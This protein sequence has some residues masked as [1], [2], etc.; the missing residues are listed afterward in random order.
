MS[1]FKRYFQ[2]NNIVFITLVT[3]NRQPILI[4]NINFLRESLINPK[5]NYKIIA[6]VVLPD[7]IH[8]LIQNDNANEFSKLISSIKVSFSKHFPLN[9]EQTEKQLLR[10]EKGIWQR[11]YYDHIIRNE[12]DFN[13]HLDYIHYN[14]IKHGY[15]NCA[16]EWEYS[17][18]KKFFKL[19]YYEE[20]WCNFEDK[21]KIN[22]LNLE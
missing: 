22:T 2:D 13:K 8:V 10:R 21:Y 19:G 9:T 11:K 4:E 14:P 3:Y 1:N 18:F 6:G 16:K 7:H 20:N 15:V 12:E 17:S 5:Y